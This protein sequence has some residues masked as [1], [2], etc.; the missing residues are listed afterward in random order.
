MPASIFGDRFIGFKEPAWHGLGKVFTDRENLSVTDA[1]AMADVNFEIHKVPNYARVPVGDGFL[2][3]ETKSFSIMREPTHDSPEWKVLSTVGKDWTPI[4]IGD[5][6]KMLDPLTDRYGVETVGAIGQGEKI[7]ITLDAGQSKIAGEDHRLFYL[8]TDHRDGAGALNI[9]FTPVRVVCQ[10]TLTVGLSSAKVS[11]SLTHHASIKEDAQWYTALFAQMLNA[12]ETVTATM[13]HLAEVGR[14]DE[15]A[16]K[17]IINSAYRQ[18]SKPRKLTLSQDIKPDDVPAKVWSML[19]N[20]KKHWVEEY[21]K[22][23]AG[24]QVLRDAAWD[25]FEVFNDEF[26]RLAYTP[27]AG[28]QAVVECEDYRRGHSDAMGSPIFGDRAEAK[29]RA[30]SEALKVAHN[31]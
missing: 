4:Q 10:N 3:I 21:E 1:V 7:F 17:G 2:N 25:R 8:V 20:D 9:A 16:I 12:K 11:A 5:L 24:V 29:A 19:L 6:A 30:F 13:N 15:K 22:R 28:W 18:A 14:V 27:W 26:S 31:A 23:Q